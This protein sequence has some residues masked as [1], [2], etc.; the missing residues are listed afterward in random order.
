MD[1]RIRCLL[2]VRAV[3]F[4]TWGFCKN[5]VLPRYFEI[6]FTDSS[7]FSQCKKRLY[8]G[9]PNFLTDVRNADESLAKLSEEITQNKQKREEQDWMVSRGYPNRL[10]YFM[11]NPSMD[12][13]WGYPSHILG[14]HCFVKWTVWPNQ[15]VRGGMEWTSSGTRVTLI[16]VTASK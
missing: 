3:G 15:Q 8:L 11:E 14:N 13:K 2:L 12:D 9:G 5:E 1:S 4:G 16:S 6:T 10:V 7:S